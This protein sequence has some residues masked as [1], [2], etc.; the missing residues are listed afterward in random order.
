M[1]QSALP[2]GVVAPP[3][4]ESPVA[5]RIARAQILEGR[6][7]VEL[8]GEAEGSRL[9]FPLGRF[10]QLETASSE[11]LADLRITA[12][13]SA[14]LFKTANMELTLDSILRHGLG[15][16]TATENARRARAVPSAA[17]SEASRANGA[18]GGRPKR[19]IVVP[20]E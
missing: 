19:R 13:G 17:R 6:L 3:A 18:R 7:E 16:V 2:V 15:V 12:N 4:R 1:K 5:P 20:A 10:P 14:L 9:S 8:G 11:S